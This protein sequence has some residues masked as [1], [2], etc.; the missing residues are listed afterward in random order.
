MNVIA[1]CYNVCCLEVGAVCELR[2]AIK[3]SA[4]LA[5]SVYTSSG[6]MHT[7]GDMVAVISFKLPVPSAVQVKGGYHRNE[8]SFIQYEFDNG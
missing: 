4:F 6:M 3:C 7:I 2:V 5:L 1:N 8:I